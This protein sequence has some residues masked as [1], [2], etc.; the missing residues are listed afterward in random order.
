M[1][2]LVYADLQATEGSIDERLRANPAIPLQRW[3]VERFYA[4]LATLYRQHDCRYLIDL[5][6][7][8]DDR[9][10]LPVPTIQ[11]VMSGLSAINPD[12][13]LSIKLIGNHEQAY[14]DST[15]HPG[16]MY[17]QF[18]HVVADREVIYAGNTAIVCMAWQEN[19]EEA[20]AWLQSTLNR[21]SLE[22]GEIATADR[23]DLNI[24]VL[25][26]LHMR[27]SWVNGV[28]LKGGLII[29]CMDSADLVL[30]GHVH[31]P[32][33]VD[34]GVYYVGSPFQQDFGEVGQTKRVGLLDLNTLDLQWL[35]LPSPFPRYL[36]LTV[37][38]LECLDSLGEDRAQVVLRTADEARRFH[39][40]PL[41]PLVEPD[42]Q[43]AP[44]ESEKGAQISDMPRVDW[45]EEWVDKKPLAGFT[46][47]ELL[48]AGRKL[49]R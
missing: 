40:C 4:D 35:P 38:E 18:H 2:A 1:R 21:I 31:Q 33:V 26:H 22:L 6:D 30:L 17:G 19:E 10:A 15:Q 9:K 43:L 12:P 24:L 7:T 20:S 47:D 48:E 49:T 32:Q 28:Q 5:G 13:S 44:I 16:L 29:T 3:R 46:R 42:Y 27:A 41:A 11:A 25:G 8:T 34:S 14:R 39:A 23:P 45:V 37:D 36:R